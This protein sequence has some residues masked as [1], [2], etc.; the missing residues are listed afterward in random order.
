MEDNLFLQTVSREGVLVLVGIQVGKDR[1]HNKSL[2]FNSHAT[3]ICLL[4]GLLGNEQICYNVMI[5]T[6]K[7]TTQEALLPQ[8]YGIIVMYSESN[9]KHLYNENHK[10]DLQK[11]SNLNC[12]YLDNSSV[13]MA[14]SSYISNKVQLLVNTII[15]NSSYYVSLRVYKLRDLTQSPPSCVY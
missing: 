8:V 5:T 11:Y 9:Q 13:K 1:Q 4:P 15:N 3:T 10:P 12:E 6:H 2:S 14:R 7:Y